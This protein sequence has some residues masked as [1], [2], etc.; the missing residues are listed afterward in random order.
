MVWKEESPPLY[1]SLMPISMVKMKADKIIIP[2]GRQN[3]CLEEVSFDGSRGLFK[4]GRIY[5]SLIIPVA[6]YQVIF[7]EQA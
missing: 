2:K 1:V 4:P 7:T 6:G 3:E 5:R